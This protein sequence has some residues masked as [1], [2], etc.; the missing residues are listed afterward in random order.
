MATLDNVKILLELDLLESKQD[1]L[2]NLYIQRSTDFIL[3]YCNLTEVPV[4]LNSVLEDIVVFR[5]RNKG[6]ENLK[7]ETLG[8][9]SASFLDGLPSDIMQQLNTHRRV[10]VI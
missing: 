1:N 8:S 7:S 4:S 6:I 5:Y 9:H 3:N 10:R 2:L